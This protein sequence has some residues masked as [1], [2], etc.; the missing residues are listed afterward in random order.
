MHHLKGLRRLLLVLP[1]ADAQFSTGQYFRPPIRRCKLRRIEDD[2]AAAMEIDP[3]AGMQLCETLSLQ[4][5][6]ERAAQDM[7]ANARDRGVVIGFRIE[8]SAFVF[9]EY[10][11]DGSWKEGCADRTFE[12]WGD[13]SSEPD[14]SFPGGRFCSTDP[15]RSGKYIPVEERPNPEEVRVNDLDGEYQLVLRSKDEDGNV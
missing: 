5:C 2:E 14:R 3:S 12:R 9:A 11:R 15:I 1:D 8:L 10:Q 6:V 4:R 7:D 13:R